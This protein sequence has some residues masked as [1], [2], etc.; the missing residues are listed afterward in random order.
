MEVK[1][2][3]MSI[4]NDLSTWERALLQ[5]AVRPSQVDTFCLQLSAAM[6][7]EGVENLDT[8]I[9]KILTDISGD[10]KAKLCSNCGYIRRFID[11]L[12][13]SKKM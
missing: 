9:L 2:A 4:V 11:I 12:L 13:K 8:L 3:Y 7:L 5:S 6:S 1:E 10:T